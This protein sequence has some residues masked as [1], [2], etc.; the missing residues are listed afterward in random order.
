MN[1]WM[2][3]MPSCHFQRCVVATTAF[4]KTVTAA[5][6]IVRRKTNTLTLVYSKALPM[7]RPNVYLNFGHRFLQKMRFPRKEAGRVFSG[8]VSDSTSNMALLT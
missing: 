7:Q 5:A 3:S 8:R 6:M 1:S 4:G 2:L